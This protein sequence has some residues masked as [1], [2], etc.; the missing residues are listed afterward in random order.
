M[1]GIGPR[2]A[3]RIVQ[4]L[5]RSSPRYVTNLS[6]S[7]AAVQKHVNQC[8]RCFKFDDVNS[9]KLCPLC[10][11]ASRDDEIVMVV[12]KDVDVDGI[13]SSNIYRGRYLVLGA[14]IPLGV[15]RKSAVSARVADLKR[16]IKNSPEL[17]EV[18]LAFATTPEGDYTA[19]ELKKT[20]AEENSAINVSMLGR[21][22]S[23]GA[24]IEYADQETLRSAFFGR[25]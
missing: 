3:R 8:V 1:P 12:E 9:A 4:F 23:L 19:N 15:K 2:Q 22:L 16:T 5:L 25:H 24:E 7:I 6:S 18:V 13:E 20:I 11:D 14:L 21:G 10:A 17:K